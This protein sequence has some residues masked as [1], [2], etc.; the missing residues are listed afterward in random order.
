MGLTERDLATKLV[1][2]I[3]EACTRD[4]DIAGSVSVAIREL[5]R[6]VASLFEEVRDLAQGHGRQ[7]RFRDRLGWASR[8]R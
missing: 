6:F 5:E 8:G 3:V 7:G 2:W 1:P 4:V